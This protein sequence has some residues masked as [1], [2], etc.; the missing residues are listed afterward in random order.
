MQENNIDKLYRDYAKKIHS[1]LFCL[2]KDNHIADDLTQETFYQA[3]KSISKF[4][5]A[6][7][8]SVWLCQIAK[9]LWFKELKKNKN[10]KVPI[11]EVG[12][13]IRST[14]DAETLIVNHIDSIDL[15]KMLHNLDEKT[16]E[17]MYLRLTGFLS[18]KEI[19]EILGESEV[20]AR[21]TF[22]RTKQKIVKEM[23]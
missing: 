14:A 21:V 11:N 23:E 16:K 13:D 15:F 3:M 7:K 2:C 6:C 12:S 17:L 10:I 19:G 4:R 20:W 5:G 9:H 18:F 22:Y 8:V 1:Y